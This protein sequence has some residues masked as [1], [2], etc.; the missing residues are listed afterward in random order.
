M[1]HTTD[2]LL[3][4]QQ[5]LSGIFPNIPITE[6]AYKVISNTFDTCTFRIRFETEPRPGFPNDLLIRVEASGSRLAAVAAFQRLGHHQLAD[7]V[8]TTLGVGTTANSK[9]RELEYSVTPYFDGTTT[10]DDVWN[11]LGSDNQRALMK[12]VVQ[13]VEKLQ[14]LDP[15]C[16]DVRRVIPQLDRTTRDLE[17]STALIGGPEVGYY[18]EIKQLLVGFAGDNGTKSPC[19]EILD[20]TNGIAIQSTFEDIDRIEFSYSD[21]D[22][23]QKHVVLCH[24]DL[25]PRNI[26]VK[27]AL[28]D[29]SGDARY[30]LVAIIDWEMAG[31]YPFAYEFGL[32]D[33]LL[34]SSNLSFSWYSLFKEQTAFLVPEGEC[35]AKLIKATRIIAE[36]EVR[37]MTRNVSVRFQAKWIKREQI[38]MSVDVRCGW[39]R[40]VDADGT[41][42]FTKEDDANLEMEVLK[43]LGYIK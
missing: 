4:D 17:L 14:K 31:F 1:A 19:C 18:S 5:I 2:G 34:G 23:L 32:K 26:L 7:V 30:E 39:V 24:N 37:T 43:D 13:A 42:L 15:Q 21:L 35:H 33:T 10:L 25:E 6:D 27:Q 36:S 22:D 40:K 11:D 20:T 41:G 12:S 28:N 38:K 8:P 29:D 3:P 16:D 9:G